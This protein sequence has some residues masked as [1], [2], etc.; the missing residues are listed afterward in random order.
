MKKK[1]RDLK[2]FGLAVGGSIKVTH[3]MGGSACDGSGFIAGAFIIEFTEHH[4]GYFYLTRDTK[5]PGSIAEIVLVNLNT[6]KLETLDIYSGGKSHQTSRALLKPGHYAVEIAQAGI[7]T[8]TS[9]IILKSGRPVSAKVARTIH[10]Q[11]EF[12]AKH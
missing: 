5:K 4:K 9:G 10:L 8:D 6:E 3:A 11:G 2:S 1:G 7:S 12:K